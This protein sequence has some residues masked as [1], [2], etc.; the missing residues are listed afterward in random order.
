MADHAARLVA[1]AR[2]L[3]AGREDDAVLDDGGRVV[4]GLA[5]DG[6]ADGRGGVDHVRLAAVGANVVDVARRAVAAGA[7]GGNLGRVVLVPVVE[8][9]AGHVVVG[10][11]GPFVQER[12]DQFGRANGV[13]CRG[14]LAGFLRLFGRGGSLLG[15]RGFFGRGRLLLGW[16]RLDGGCGGRFLGRLVCLLRRGV[17]L[18]GNGQ[19]AQEQNEDSQ[20][21]QRPCFRSHTL[22][23]LYPKCNNVMR[24]CFI[25]ELGSHPG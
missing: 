5:L 12:D 25:A 13:D 1:Q 20:E 15:G 22:Y 24:R 4:T 6:C 8:R 16:R 17:V 19:Q 2:Y 7:I 14:G 9:F 18:T 10:R 3:D 21:G 23:L 11:R